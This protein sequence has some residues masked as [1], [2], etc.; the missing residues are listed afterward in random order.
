MTAPR[1]CR[2]PEG[3]PDKTI[4]WL[5]RY[6]ENGNV[7]DRQPWLYRDRQG[8]A[9]YWIQHGGGNKWRT[10]DMADYGWRFHSI[11]EPPHE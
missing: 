10:Q 2:P 9:P 8:W 5:F 6:D 7:R 3:T 11:A 4:C 1:E